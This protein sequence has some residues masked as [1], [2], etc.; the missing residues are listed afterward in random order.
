MSHKKLRLVL[1]VV[2][3]STTMAC[4][5]GGLASKQEQPTATGRPRVEATMVVV[6]TVV[7]EK[8]MTVVEAV[9][10]EGMV[11]A[12]SEAMPAAE[13]APGAMFFEEYG[14]NPFIDTED[15]HLSTFALDVD[16]GSYTVAR[17][18]VQ[19]GYLPPEEAVRVEEFVN[20]FD[21]GYELPS[22]ADAFAIYVDGAPF[23]FSET[24]RYEMLRVGIQGYAVPPEERK[25]VSLTFVIDVSGSMD[26]ENR[27][28][29]VKRSLELLVE[30]LG[31][32]DSVGIVVY[33][34]DARVV[35]EPTSGED[36]GTILE[37]IYRL[38][39]EG[40][41]NAEG[42][43]RL[44][45][46][47]A[48]RA[49]KPGAIN[50]VIL[51]SDGVANV[52]QTGPESILEVISGYASEGITLTSV[53]FGMGNY[54]DVLM[55][56]LADKGDGFYAYVDTL[57][58]AERLFVHGLTGTLQTIAMDAKVQ[59]DFDPGVVAR[60]RL[61]GFENRAIADEQFRDDTVDAGEIGAGHSVTALYE[62]KLHPEAEGR[63][64]TV[65]LRWRDPETA[66][67]M[68]LSQG[69]YTEDLAERFT[70]ADPHFQCAVVVAEYAEVL[71]GSYWAE[72]NTLAGV[73]EEA[74]RVAE[75]VPEDTD[76][77]EFV[78]L[79]RQ[80]ARISGRE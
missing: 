48:N 19:D 10:V 45:Y 79:V 11:P 64:A 15:D 41:T 35:L 54:N 25:D 14:V 22:E 60:Y 8:E 9:E 20:Y 13:Q 30:Q 5:L 77:A 38:Q 12:P 63:I 76:V 57:A 40:A 24:E 61:V 70:D 46:E 59:V 42:G 52:G 44:G 36:K 4:G 26:M 28:E 23:P 50:R 55:E 73:L 39:P 66:E 34:S 27:L 32:A 37:A 31:P 29:L 17:R 6:E 74:E 69:F 78:E 71:R 7:V 72:G 80:A 18:Y 62:I 47:R 49:F 1:L 67:V 56:Q 2:L 3:L 58:E 21:Q 43:L 53:G 75:L 16:T 51:C 65:H 33:G 68:E